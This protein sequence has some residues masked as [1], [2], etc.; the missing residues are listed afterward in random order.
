MGESGVRNAT[1]SLWAARF[2]ALRLRPP[3]ASCGSI[4][5]RGLPSHG[6]PMEPRAGDAALFIDWID[7]SLVSIAENHVSKV[8]APLAGASQSVH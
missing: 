6:R 3:T 8:M 4:H 2:R 5:C 7:A 1:K